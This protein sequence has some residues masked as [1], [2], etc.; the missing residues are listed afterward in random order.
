MTAGLL[1]GCYAAAAGLLAA[2]GWLA[3]AALRRRWALRRP[4]LAISMWL[5]LA[6]AWVVAVTLTALAAVPVSL[7]WARDVPGGMPMAGAAPG[8]PAVAVAGALLAA[9]VVLRVCWCLA[10]DLRRGRRERRGHA[11]FVAAAGRPD[12]ELG[13]VVIDD[14]LPLAYCLPGGGHRVVVSTAALAVLEPAQLRAVLAHER[15][16]LRRRHHVLLTVAS[17]LARAS[18]RVPLLAQAGREVAVLAEMAADDAAA[19]SHDP[20]SLAAALVLLARAGTRAAALTAGSPAAAVRVER[21]LTMGAR[22]RRAGR[23]AGLASAA[24]SLAVPLAVICL[25]LLAAACSAAGR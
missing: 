25:P 12:R 1:L 16:H 19:R 9:A 6:L 18:G 13:A 17:A 2:T 22:P 10:S 15:A 8:G 3:P 24:A 21:L 11:A 14:G 20:G 5:A 23:I 4:G 7:S